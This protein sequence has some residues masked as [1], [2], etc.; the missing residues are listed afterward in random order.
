[1]LSAT[2]CKNDFTETPKAPTKTWILQTIEAVWFIAR[3]HFAVFIAKD[4]GII[5]RT[6]SYWRARGR[7]TQDGLSV[8]VCTPRTNAI[9]TEGDHEL[10]QG[11]P[12]NARNWRGY[13][14]LIEFLSAPNPTERRAL[15]PAV[16]TAYGLQSIIQHGADF[17]QD[18][19][20]GC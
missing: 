20:T 7:T 16:F 15:A 9:L 12:L 2:W 8:E 18:T 10:C 17:P 4:L 6:G 3:E 13:L 1:L 19:G 11:L 5:K 14:L